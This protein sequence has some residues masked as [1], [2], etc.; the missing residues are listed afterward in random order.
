VYVSKGGY[1]ILSGGTI[2][3]N[4]AHGA[5]GGVFVEFGG[6]FD[7]DPKGRTINRNTGQGAASGVYMEKG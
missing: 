2:T 6:G 5:G 3:G 7:Y 4:R 1:F